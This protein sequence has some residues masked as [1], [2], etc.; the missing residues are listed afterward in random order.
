MSLIRLNNVSKN[1]DDT[2]VLREVYFRL[3]EGDGR[4]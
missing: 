3:S 1:Y 4:A 2:P